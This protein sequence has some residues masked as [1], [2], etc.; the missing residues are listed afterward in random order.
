MRVTGALI[1][2]AWALVAT[3]ASAQTVG[4][5]LS[6][7]GYAAA[8][9]TLATTV[10]QFDETRPESAQA[11]L[12]ALPLRWHVSLGAR[13]IDISSD[14]LRADLVAWQRHPNASARTQLA[15]H[16]RR[17]SAEAAAAVGPA[18]ETTGPRAR[19][20]GIL[21]Q[22]EFDGARGPSWFDRLLERALL[23]LLRV[24]G[25]AITSSTMSIATTVLVYTLIGAA[26]VLVVVV[27]YRAVRYGTRLDPLHL[28]SADR[29]PAAVAYT[30]AEA[31]AARGDWRDAITLAY[32]WGIQT[33]EAR[34]VWRP[35][36]TRTPREYL[37]QL[38]ADSPQ[39][40]SLR[41]LTQLIERVRYAGDAGDASGFDEAT[42]HLRHL[43][44]LRV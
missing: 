10:E 22:R 23:W 28:E 2:C 6:P 37:R 41:A 40:S 8:I 34:G 29:P 20:D 5:V 4:P 21:A 12:D 16:L 18:D 24:L 14:W 15:A 26:L 25:V 32:W 38:P 27:M 39:A 43:G 44:C 35:D 17:V 13:V 36:R 1:A 7:S 9:G 11:V 42:T 33:L 30:D 3:A 31:A 19:L